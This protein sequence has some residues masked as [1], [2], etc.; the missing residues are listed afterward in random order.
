MLHRTG[1]LTELCYLGP[2]PMSTNQFYEA[3]DH[4]FNLLQTWLIRTEGNIKNQEVQWG[5]VD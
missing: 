2:V 5:R 4:D 1:L 3:Y